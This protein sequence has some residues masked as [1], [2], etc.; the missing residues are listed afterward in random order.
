ML[1][2][3]G[4]PLT[5]DERMLFTELT[6]RDREPVEPVRQF[7]GVV[8]RR[9]GKS[10]AMGTLAAYLSGCCDFRDVLAPGQRAR[11][12]LIAA[13]KEQADELFAYVL[14]AFEAAPALA[15]LIDKANER[16]LQLKSQVDVQ[17]RALSFRNL[18]GSTNIAVVADELA[19]W[20]SD[21]SATPDKAVIDA[22]KPSL[23][24]THGPLIGIS[25]PYSRKGVL[26]RAFVRDYGQDGR[27]RV[28]IAKGAT[29]LFNPG[30]DQAFLDDAYADDPVAADAE[31]GA[32]WRDDI[33][34]FIASEVVE[35]AVVPGLFELPYVEGTT[36]TAFTDA[37]GGS[38]SDSFTLAIAHSEEV[39]GTRA[40]V[41][42][43]DCIREIRPP[44]SP[45]AATAQMAE[46]LKAYH[47]S[48]VTGDA[49]GGAWPAERFKAH[50]ITYKLSTRVQVADKAVNDGKQGPLYRSEIYKTLLPM[51]NAGRVR[52]LDHKRMVTQLMSLERR[53]TTS[54]QDSVNHPTGG[55]DDLI[56]AA[57]GALVLS[58]FVR[59]P[60]VISAELLAAVSRR[61]GEPMSLSAA[62]QSQPAEAVSQWILIPRTQPISK[63]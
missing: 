11:L 62:T 34:A 7:F 47:L 38:G 57:A 48:T 22:L 18:R 33:A 8:G 10:R 44:F 31:Y 26:Y 29:K 6:G 13:S 21:E 12:P 5:D 25:S 30:I 60:M 24:T 49:Y 27:P 52:L 58:T 14:G 56:N 23:A 59:R 9:G 54:G 43:L 42:V 61:P 28:L 40:R 55:H 45:D 20:R 3:V 36:Y 2:I 37:A 1:A 39:P 19:Y 51:L 50:G 16:T 32:N 4:E 17:V 63:S 41:G 35:A 15:H 53:T 46:T